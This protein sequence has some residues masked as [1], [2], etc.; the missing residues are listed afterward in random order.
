MQLVIITFFL[1]PLLGFLL[2]L[3][4]KNHQEKQISGVAIATSGLHM[5]FT[6]SFFIYWLTQGNPTINSHL[7]TIYKSEEF[8]FG[9]DLFYD[10]VSAVYSIV[11]SIIFFIVSIFSHKNWLRLFLMYR[12]TDRC[13][14]YISEHIAKFFN[15]FYLFFF[16]NFW[17]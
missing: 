15:K 4:F 17:R 14:I 11:T 10:K 1:L 9:F 7:L 12:K 8:N 2:S 16:G 5:I 13:S 3:A 6:I